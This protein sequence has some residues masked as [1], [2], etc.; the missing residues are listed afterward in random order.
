M[1]PLALNTVKMSV[2]GPAPPAEK[3]DDEETIRKCEALIV[4]SRNRDH[5]Q[6]KDLLRISDVNV[7]YKDQKG[8]TAFHIAATKWRQSTPRAFPESPGY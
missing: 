3:P 5:D 4:A 8:N 6:A 7:N 2:C 1:F